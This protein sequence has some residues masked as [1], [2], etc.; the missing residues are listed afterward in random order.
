MTDPVIWG[1]SAL[2]HDASIAVTQGNEILFAAHSERYSRKKFDPNLNTAL[3]KDAMQYGKPDVIGWGERPYLRKARQV[4]AGQYD[5][6]FDRHKLPS[7]ELAKFG[8]DKVPVKYFRHHKCHAAA[9]FYTS[10]YDDAAIVVI[11]A[12]GE[13]DTITIW[14]GRNGKLTIRD[15]TS[16]PHSLGLLYSA[17]TQHLGFSPNSEEYFTMGMAAYGEPTEIDALVEHVVESIDPF[18]LKENVH[19]G[20]PR[21]FKDPGFW[22]LLSVSPDTEKFAQYQADL[23]ASVQLIAEEVI[24]ATVRKA[25]KLINSDNLIMG[26]GVALNCLANKLLPQVYDNIWIMP[27]PG[28]AGNSLGAA[29]LVHGEK[30]NWVGPYLGYDADDV[31]FCMPI[32]SGYPVDRLLETIL[33]KGV[34]GVIYGRAEFGP[35]AFG[36]RSLLADP[37]QPDQQTALN[38]YKE[39]EAFRP[40]APVVLEEH[41]HEFFDMP[42]ASSPYMQFVWEAKHADLIPAVVHHDG[43]S[44]VQ[45]VNAE[46]HGG[47]HKLITG[48]YEETGIPMLVNTSLNIKGSPLANRR[49]DGYSFQSESGI[50][51]FW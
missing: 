40:F 3:V 15:K 41:A 1:I 21:S 50:P 30:F 42:I 11:D 36:N 49:V 37:R 33:Q 44:R 5:S 25:R 47:L 29:A 39:R 4:L 27:N 43:T 10:T 7:Y 51:V 23:A 34:A 24:M 18:R 46:Q 48:F 14:E 17:V 16:Y 6:A 20:L 8:L 38:K 28:D 12:I 22:G 13:F 19:R 2:G 9:G 31:G 32:T 26:G 45:T 35:R